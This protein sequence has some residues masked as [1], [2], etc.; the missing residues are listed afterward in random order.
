MQTIIENNTTPILG[1]YDVIVVGGGVGGVSAAI[2]ARRNNS[3]RVLLIEKGVQFGGLATNGLISWYE[4]ICDGLGNKLMYGMADEMMQLAMQYGP[5][6]LPDEWQ[7]NPDNISSK[8][9]F[10]THFLQLCLYLHWINYLSKA[11]LICFL[12]HK[13]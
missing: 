10:A 3:K 7:G 4:P 8:K 11:A 9:R 13:L 12:T 5:D 2:S 1:E 6:C